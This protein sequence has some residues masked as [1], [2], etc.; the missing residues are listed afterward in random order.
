MFDKPGTALIMKSF[1][2]IPSFI[3]A[4]S[5]FSGVSVGARSS[6]DYLELSPLYF[7]GTVQVEHHAIPGNFDGFKMK[8][9]AAHK[10]IISGTIPI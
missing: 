6:R 9:P 2:N 8:T 3:A 7:N 5:L 10:P 4:R 1:L